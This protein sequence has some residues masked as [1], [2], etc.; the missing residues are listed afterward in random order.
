VFTARYALSPYIKQI[1]FVF[2]GLKRNISSI[3]RHHYK[4]SDLQR[5]EISLEI[6]ISYFRTSISTQYTNRISVSKSER[7]SI[8]IFFQETNS[9]KHP[10][11]ILYGPYKD[12][13]LPYD[14]ATAFARSKETVQ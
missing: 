8:Y 2:E 3:T 7:N 12:V 9:W 4:T 5:G 13:A 1:R 11:R 6:P 10:V 14:K